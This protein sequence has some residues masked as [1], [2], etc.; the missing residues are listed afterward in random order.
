M[1]N[2]LIQIHNGKFGVD[3]SYRS[4]KH[5][6]GCLLF[7]ETAGIGGCQYFGRQRIGPENLKFPDNLE[8][9]FSF[10]IVK[11]QTFY[12]AYFA[13]ARHQNKLC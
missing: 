8:K 4:P 10:M 5:K 11:K 7:K 3:G 9:V 1:N 6:C 13:I 2:I 12:G